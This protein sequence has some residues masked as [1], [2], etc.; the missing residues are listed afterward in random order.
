MFYW[1]QSYQSTYMAQKFF[2]FLVP[3]VTPLAVIQ[4]S[5]PVTAPKITD[6]ELTNI[7]ARPSKDEPQT[8]ST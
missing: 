5:H 4:K 7:L 1:L 3:T 8:Q 2:I 6:K